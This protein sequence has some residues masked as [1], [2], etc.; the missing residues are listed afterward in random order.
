MAQV[1]WKEARVWTVSWPG[2]HD[3]VPDGKHVPDVL[4]ILPGV[5]EYDDAVWAKAKKVQDVKERLESGQLKEISGARPAGKDATI[6]QGLPKTLGKFSVQDAVELVGGV[7]EMDMLKAWLKVE[8][9]TTVKDAII[10][11]LKA[12]K[13]EDEKKDE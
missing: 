11:Q 3:S 4:R 5:H 12:L 6:E 13:P 7:M 8:K 1:H 2:A 9:R 10:K